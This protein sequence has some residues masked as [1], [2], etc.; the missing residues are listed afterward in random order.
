MKFDGNYAYEITKKLSYPRMV[1]SEGEKRARDDIEKWMRD[2]GLETFREDFLAS[3]FPMGVLARWVMLV[4]SIPLLLSAISYRAG[5]PL[6]AFLLA[7]LTICAIWRT[8]RIAN[9]FKD[10][11]KYGKQVPTQNIV[12]RFTPKEE[13]A[14]VVLMAHFD[15][16]S[17]PFPIELRILAYLVSALAIA[18]ALIA[19]L[20][21]A[22]GAMLGFWEPEG[23]IILVI[24]IIATLVSAS[25]VFN[26]VEN[27]S[28]G[29]LD[30]AAG[31]GVI[32]GIAKAWLEKPFDDITL[33]VVATSAE[34]WG[35]QGAQRWIEKHTPEYP[36]DRTIF[37]NYDGPGAKGGRIIITSRF[38]LPP[39]EISGAEL[40]QDFESACRE[41][42]IKNA[43][44][45]YIPFGASTD[46]M[47]V[48]EKGFRVLN[49]GSL[50]RGVHTVRDNMDNIDAGELQKAGD[51]GL[52]VI[53]KFRIR[54]TK[55]L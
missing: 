2:I 22:S 15:T 1:G 27:K 24:S 42:A 17:Q 39:R 53:Q 20:I 10:F 19:V 45:V 40:K 9:N 35:L 51:I 52:K 25:L 3:D 18:I 5:L 47:P 34:E 44:D 7:L 6:L 8:A 46:M 28:V 11:L 29:S 30:N 50:S 49:I 43:R 21:G 48:S 54:M 38:G 4:I 23:K 33:T 37:L 14:H 36:K 12:G 41:L 32:L 26:K 13:K 16:K 55:A 31:V